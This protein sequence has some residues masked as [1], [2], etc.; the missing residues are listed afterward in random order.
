MRKWNVGSK[1]QTKSSH[2]ADKFFHICGTCK[3]SERIRMLQAPSQAGCLTNL[4]WGFQTHE[5]LLVFH[6]LFFHEL[7]FHELA[8]RGRHQRA[9]CENEWA[10]PCVHVLFVR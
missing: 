8:F 10:K 4:F 3:K 9:L 6:E 1:G 2:W 5:F 7:F